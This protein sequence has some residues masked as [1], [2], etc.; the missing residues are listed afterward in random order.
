MCPRCGGR[1]MLDVLDNDRYCIN[2]GWRETPA[3]LLPW[4]AKGDRG[5]SPPDSRMRQPRRRREETK[6]D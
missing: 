3:K 6:S 1:L 4:I 2:C 5:V